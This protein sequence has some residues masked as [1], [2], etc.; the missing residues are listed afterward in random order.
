[1]A[2][3]EKTKKAR[4]RSPLSPVIPLERA[5]ER[6]REF[7]DAG[8]RDHPAPFAAAV[9]T[10]G[11]NAKSSG[12]M[13]TVATLKQFGLMVDEGSGEHRQVK[14]TDLALRIIRDKRE[15]SA[16]RDEAVRQAALS[17]KIHREMHN[18][19]GASLPPEATVVYHLVHQL[20]FSENAATALFGEYQDTI[21][22]ANLAE[23]AKMPEQVGDLSEPSTG[24]SHIISPGAEQLGSSTT[25]P[26]VTVEREFLRGPLSRD[27][28]FRL[29]VTGEFGPTGIG[30]L[31][32]VLELQQE[33]LSDDD[34]DGEKPD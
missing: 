9:G 3:V 34:G 16:E 2:E 1:M 26:Q 13:Q 17:P 18:K 32:R 14:L 12:G 10:W 21:K 19:W 23:P 15:R 31:I 24:V 33:L 30:K 20:S 25:A 8:H 29:L 22:L 5:I 28:G 27:V 7:Y 6:A 11:Y 4:H